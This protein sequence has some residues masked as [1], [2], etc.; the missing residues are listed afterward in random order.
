MQTE[1]NNA[2]TLF[3]DLIGTMKHAVKGSIKY[4]EAFKQP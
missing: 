4:S 2:N 1:S 3:Q